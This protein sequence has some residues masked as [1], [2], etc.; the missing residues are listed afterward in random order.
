MRAQLLA[1]LLVSGSTLAAEAD[2]P[3]APATP[4]PNTIVTFKEPEKFVDAGT[5]GLGS[6]TSPRVLESLKKHLEQLGA[7]Q[8]PP[9]QTLQIVIT[10]IDLAGRFE[11][12]G[13]LDHRVRLMRDV[14]WPRMDLHYTLTQDGRT[15]KEADEHLADM[16]YLM[17]S[18]L[19]HSDDSLRY[20]KSMLDRWFAKTFGGRS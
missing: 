14:D 2:A 20:E 5:E 7:K 13:A 10:N 18:T 17:N 3:A 6:R 8:L 4:E 19:K 12:H 15:L 11:L 1:L 16:S 9:G